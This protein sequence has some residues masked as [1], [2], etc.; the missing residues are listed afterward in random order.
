MLHGL[1]ANEN[2]PA[3]SVAVL[4]AHGFDVWAV[5]EAGS[6]ISDI[7]VLERSTR[8][9][10]WILTFDKD[11]GELIF[12]CHMVP[13]PAI[14]F[15]RMINYIPTDPAERVLPILTNPVHQAQGGY[16]VISDRHL[17]HRPLAGRAHTG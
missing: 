3:P 14:L 2:F 6:G 7:E 15:F 10:R 11:Y 9:A 12:R 4:R 16:F 1:L 5:A 17:R 8:E 13:P